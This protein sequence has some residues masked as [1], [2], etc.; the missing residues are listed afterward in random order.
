MNKKGDLSLSIQT[1]VIVVIAFT[2]LGLG[3]TFVKEQIGSIGKTAKDVQVEIRSKILDDLR[4]SGK[5]LSISEEIALERNKETIVGIGVV[6][7]GISTKK[8]GVCI[9]PI[10]KQSLDGTPGT[11][12]EMKKE[13]NFFYNAEVEKE[14]SPTQGDVIA[15]TV[16]AR[17]TA[18]GNYLYKVN[19]YSEDTPG[20]CSVPTENCPTPSGGCTL[21]DTKSF[22]VKVR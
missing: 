15:A 7:T 18:S 21:Y 4:S 5:K 11:I 12:E 19:A 3:L 14:L 9:E 1:I 20:A 13:V 17:G 22:F 16:S 8:Y 6:N 10:R 2:V